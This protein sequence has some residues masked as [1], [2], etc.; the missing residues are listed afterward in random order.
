MRSDGSAIHLHTQTVTVVD[1]SPVHGLVCCA[2][3]DGVLECVDIRQPS[4]VGSL[5]IASALEKVRRG[6]EFVS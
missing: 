3:N 5:D 1:V 2:G 6:L 4:I